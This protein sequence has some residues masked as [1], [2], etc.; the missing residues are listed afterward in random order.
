MVRIRRITDERRL[1]EDA[2]RSHQ[3]GDLDAALRNYDALL[4]AHP[5]NA[6][7]LANRASVH[8][9]RGDAEAAERDARRAAAIDA[10][11]FGAWFNLGLAL[12]QRGDVA[13]ASSSLRHASELR[14]DDARALLE[15]F[16]AAAHSQQFAGIAARIRQ[17]IPNLAP[18]RDLAMLTATELEQHGAATAAFVVLSNLRRE[19]PGDQEVVVRFMREF[20]YAKA[21]L[22]E[23][24]RE[25]N[26]ALAAAGRILSH[27]PDHRGARMLRASV[28]SE[29]GETA[30]AC[31]ELREIV[32][33]V[34]DDAI[35]GSALLIA[36]QH[37]P[38]QSA[39]EI[40]EAHREWAQRYMPRVAPRRRG[41]D[42]DRP[43]R[44]GWISPRFFDGLVGNFFLPVLRQLDRTAMTHVL[45]SN[46]GIDDETSR[47]FRA[48]ADAFHRIDELDDAALCERIRA[49]RIDI[50]VEMSGHSPGNRLRALASRPA[51][52]QVSSLD[53]FHSTGTNAVDVLISDAVLTPEESLANYTEQVIR[54]PSGRLCYSPPV[55]APDIVEREPGPLRF[56]SFNRVDK[57]NDRV[58]A[59]WSR[60]L[61]AVP[62]S[63]LRLKARAFDGLDDRRHFV[64]RAAR[65]GIAEN[66]LELVGYGDH[67]EVMH[68]YSDCDIGL[69]PFPFSGCAT[70]FDA[71]WMGLPVVTK[72]GDT[73]V[74]RQTASI[75]SALDL[76]ECIAANDDEYV[77]LATALANGR[78]RRDAMRVALRARMRDRVCDVARHASELGDALR[79]AWRSSCGAR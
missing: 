73:M 11:S 19:L 35:A 13:N 23:Q 10:A 20:A 37:D 51:L 45:Y 34:P 56:C 52:L 42:P 39:H 8:L 63:A 32:H 58:L 31:V 77:A 53:Y 7:M 46:A 21:A 60:I 48:S 18:H 69:D 25:V 71:L 41:D 22:Q 78:E 64:G 79:E 2:L 26:A 74:G 27:A 3:H 9:A 44:I 36:K 1:L 38:S 54:L 72:I 15:W 43:L 65:H 61:D 59:C 29:R 49:D 40:A 55:D 66:R 24:R 57:L 62:D 30:D 50:L 14:R 67:A 47:A 4:N 16:S 5:D 6:A 70:S 17:P 12:R 28:S 76:D 33:R 75:L 68:A